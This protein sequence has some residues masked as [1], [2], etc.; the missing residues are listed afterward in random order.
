MDQHQQVAQMEI[1]TPAAFP[2]SASIDFEPVRFV[3]AA[4]PPRRFYRTI[5]RGLVLRAVVLYAASTPMNNN[6]D[7]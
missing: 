5:W 4:L 3:D 1:D 6:D 7:E 2:P